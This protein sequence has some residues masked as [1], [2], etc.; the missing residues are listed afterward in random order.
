MRIQGPISAPFC[1]PSVGVSVLERGGDVSRWGKK[2]TFCGKGTP[3]TVVLAPGSGEQYAQI[4]FIALEGDQH[5]RSI[6]H[7]KQVHLFQ[8]EQA[9]LIFGVESPAWTC[10][11]LYRSITF[12]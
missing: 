11:N 12:L 1:D 2:S 8:S 10:N 3:F 7:F 9:F 5:V 4:A 6:W